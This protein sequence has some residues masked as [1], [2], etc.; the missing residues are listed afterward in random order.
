VVATPFLR[1]FVWNDCN[2]IEVFYLKR[3]EHVNVVAAISNIVSNGK[4][5]KG[6]IMTRLWYFFV[7]SYDKLLLDSIFM[8]LVSYNSSKFS[9][10][11][12][13]LTSWLQ[14]YENLLI[15]NILIFKNENYYFICFEYF[16][17]L[18]QI[19]QFLELYWITIFKIFDE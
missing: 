9:V 6:V 1:F 11:H 16:H 3:F 14:I 10:T 4:Y 19:K 12:L 7:I 15:N 5:T 8:T 2:D 17:I 18:K 13:C